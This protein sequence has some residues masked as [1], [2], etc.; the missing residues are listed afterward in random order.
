MTKVV[1]FSCL[2]IVAFSRLSDHAQCRT[3]LIIAVK[4]LVSWSLSPVLFFCCCT[5]VQMNVSDQRFRPESS[6]WLHTVVCTDAFSCLEIA[7]KQE[8]D[9]PVFFFSEV[10][11]ELFGFFPPMLKC[12]GSLLKAH[13]HSQLTPDRDR[14]ANKCVRQN[15]RVE[16]PYELLF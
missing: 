13:V 2:K 12:T 16:I 6:S 14:R 1:F 11:T 10:T 4:A 8:P 3:F 7:L 9:L 15:A 5:G